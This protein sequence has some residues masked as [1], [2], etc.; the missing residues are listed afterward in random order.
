MY[1]Y[2]GTDFGCL[3]WFFLH[4]IVSDKAN[5]LDVGN[6]V[7]PCP[8]EEDNKLI[9]AKSPNAVNPLVWDY[10]VCICCISPLFL[11]HIIPKFANQIFSDY[12]D[13][14]VLFDFMSNAFW[15]LVT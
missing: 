6:A 13:V 3:I 9:V 12:I 1:V 5:K 11:V 2:L 10:S 4:L 15:L 14:H 7:N 8:T